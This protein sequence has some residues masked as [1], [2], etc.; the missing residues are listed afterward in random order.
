MAQV[1]LKIEYD[2]EDVRVETEGCLPITSGRL[3]EMAHQMV[4]EWLAK[5]A[6]GGQDD[7]EEHPIQFRMSLCKKHS[8]DVHDEIAATA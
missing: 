7:S 4:D 1:L 2:D 6:N 8:K 3:K 5:V